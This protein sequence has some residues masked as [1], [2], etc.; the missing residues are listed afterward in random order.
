MVKLIRQKQI[1]SELKEIHHID[2]ESVIHYSCYSLSRE[3]FYL[4]CYSIK[5][6]NYIGVLEMKNFKMIDILTLDSDIYKIELSNDE[7]RL[8]VRA[9]IGCFY[10]LDVESRKMIRHFKLENAKNKEKLRFKS[11]QF[12]EKGLGAYLTGDNMNLKHLHFLSGQITEIPTR[13]ME[14]DLDYNCCAISSNMK[15]LYGGSY[16][17]TVGCLSLKK[18]LKYKT[19]KALHDTEK[20]AS[21]V[22]NQ[23]NT[24]LFL[25]NWSEELYIMDTR[26]WKLKEVRSFGGA[27]GPILLKTTPG[28]VIGG[29]GGYGMFIIR[30][31]SPFQLLFCLDCLD[32]F[33]DFNI[34]N[35]YILID[36]F[37]AGTQIFTNDFGNKL[38]KQTAKDKDK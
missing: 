7:K 9:D 29:G 14:T 22:L 6:T 38:Y 18:G 1:D 36:D 35:K 27:E 26:N 3:E 33:N 19:V 5:K 31:T 12:C 21:N 34:S 24:V 32:N 23:E 13:T 25:G 28:Y 8:L 16:T 4:G 2:L 15:L 10:L 20:F 11:F 17:R 30:D 37:D